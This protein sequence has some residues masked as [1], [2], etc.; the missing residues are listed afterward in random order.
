MQSRLQRQAQVSPLLVHYHYF[1][2]VTKLGDSC[3]EG[4]LEPPRATKKRQQPIAHDPDAKP[5]PPP[6]NVITARSLQDEQKWRAKPMRI[7]PENRIK[8][9]KRNPIP[10]LSAK[11]QENANTAHNLRPIGP[12]L[13]LANHPKKR[14]SKA[15]PNFDLQLTT[16]KRSRSPTPSESVLTDDCCDELPLISEGWE[17]DNTT[18]ATDPVEIEGCEVPAPKRSRTDV[19]VGSLRPPASRKKVYRISVCFSILMDVRPFRPGIF[20]RLPNF[21]RNDCFSLALMTKAQRIVAITALQAG[22]RPFI[23]TKA[24]PIL[25]PIPLSISSLRTVGTPF[26]QPPA[27]GLETTQA[28]TGPYFAVVPA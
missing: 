9:A 20:D 11:A 13:E 28:P 18:P 1:F 22:P 25:L 10:Q 7:A 19:A 3:Q 16:L 23:L 6:Q 12:N 8:P 26:N 21:P 17:Q 2:L 14:I 4:L 27:N 15:M 5:V 24:V